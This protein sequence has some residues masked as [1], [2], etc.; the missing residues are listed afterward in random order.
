MQDADVFAPVDPD[1]HLLAEPELTDQDYAN[2]DYDA[3]GPVALR[4]DD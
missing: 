3:Y 1:D 4:D 2:E